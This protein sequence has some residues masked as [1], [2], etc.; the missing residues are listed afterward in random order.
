MS[1][2]R[3]R[4]ATDRRSLQ[5]S[6]ASFV[7]TERQSITSMRLQRAGSSDD[8]AAA[9]AHTPTEALHLARIGALL[10]SLDG[11]FRLGKE[12]ARGRFGSVYEV[13]VAVSSTVHSA[14]KIFQRAQMIP[15]DES[16]ARK[17][18][19]ILQKLGIHKRIVSARE[20]LEDPSYLCFTMEYLEGGSLIDFLTGRS[21]Y[22]ETDARRVMASL[23]EAVHHCHER[24]VAHR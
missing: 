6:R 24:S 11:G 13:R 1:I 19:S 18:F 20:F 9:S 8:T 17:E 15:E 12:L 3:A 4:D 7:R 10:G 2:A 23:I 21:A 5:L 22:S 16:R 14:I